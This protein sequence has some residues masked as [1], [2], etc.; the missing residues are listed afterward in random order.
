MHVGA[1]TMM[2]NPCGCHIV[3]SVGDPQVLNTWVHYA[4]L[5]TTFLGVSIHALPS[6]N[7]PLKYHILA[8]HD[9]FGFFQ[10][11]YLEDSEYYLLD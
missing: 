3:C 2:L 1:T 5:S 4:S 7:V 6:R 10:I 11:P 9:L 8:G